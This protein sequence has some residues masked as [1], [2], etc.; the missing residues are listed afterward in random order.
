MAIFDPITANINPIDP[1]IPQGQGEAPAATG[2]ASL[3]KLFMSADAAPTRAPTQDE[4]FAQRWDEFRQVST[5]PDVTPGTA[6]IC[7]LYTSD[8][9]D[10]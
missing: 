1:I 8:A 5:S 7:L 3:S 6:S 2:L 9:A 4:T 10:E